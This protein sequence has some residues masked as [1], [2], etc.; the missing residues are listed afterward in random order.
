MD[1][2][3]I[4]LKLSQKK[5]AVWIQNAIRSA[6]VAGVHNFQMDPKR[7]IVCKSNSGVLLIYFC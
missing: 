1:E 3:M 7:M 4:Q 6:K 5:K 2:A